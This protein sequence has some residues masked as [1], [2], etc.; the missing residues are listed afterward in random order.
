MTNE[1]KQYVLLKARSFK[2]SNTTTYYK[3]LFFYFTHFNTHCT[4]IVCYCVAEGQEGRKPD[5]SKARQARGS[6]SKIAQDD[7]D[8][9][10]NAIKN[11]EQ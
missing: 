11:G 5:E 2:H 1:C 6:R 4:F 3:Q 10:V 9:L 8:G 7:L